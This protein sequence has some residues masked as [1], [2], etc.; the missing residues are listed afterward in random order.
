MGKQAALYLPTGCQSLA[1]AQSPTPGEA[2]IKLAGKGREKVTAKPKY[3][4]NPHTS[5]YRSNADELCV[6]HRMTFWYERNPTILMG[7]LF[8]CNVIVVSGADTG[9]GCQ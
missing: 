3:V 1:R 2:R 4:R 9:E 5:A 6:A 7:L 8:Y